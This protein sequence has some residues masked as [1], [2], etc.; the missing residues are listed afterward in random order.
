MPNCT[1]CKNGNSCE[2]CNTNVSIKKGDKCICKNGYHE[3]AASI[4]VK[5]SNTSCQCN[6]DSYSH[7]VYYYGWFRFF[8]WKKH[9][10]DYKKVYLCDINH[11]CKDYFYCN[12]D[13]ACNEFLDKCHK[14]HNCTKDFRK[15]FFDHCHI[16][17]NCHNLFGYDKSGKYGGYKA[18]CN[19]CKKSCSCDK[20]NTNFT[21]YNPYTFSWNCFI[22][23]SNNK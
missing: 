8:D 17:G 3:D 13:K 12:G 20:P 9:Y 10:I 21:Y 18:I 2:V 6:C 15:N 7:Y 4:C 14:E 22:F 16:Y 5:G 23:G 1:K 11:D 19:N